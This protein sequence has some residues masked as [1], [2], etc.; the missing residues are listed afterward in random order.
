MI[1]GNAMPKLSDIACRP[2]ETSRGGINVGADHQCICGCEFCFVRANPNPPVHYPG[3]A[4]L[5]NIR[6]QI[7]EGQKYGITSFL[8]FSM[9][10]V[11]ICSHPQIRDILAMLG[12]EFPHVTFTIFTSG[13]VLPMDML[14]QLMYP[15]LELWI[16]VH[17][18]DPACRERLGLRGN[19]QAIRQL[20]PHARGG[21]ILEPFWDLDI[22]K[23]DIDEVR[24]TGFDGTFIVRRLE[25]TRYSTKIGTDASRASYRQYLPALEHARSVYPRVESVPVLPHVECKIPTSTHRAM[26]EAEAHSIRQQVKSLKGRVLFLTSVLAYWF[27]ADALDT[28]DHVTVGTMSAGYYG[29]SIE[30]AGLLTRDDI[31]RALAQYRDHRYQ[32]LCLPSRMKSQIMPGAVEAAG[33]MHP[34]DT[35]DD[36]KE[37]SGMRVLFIGK[38]IRDPV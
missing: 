7:Q 19:V 3:F 13:I 36:L 37:L 38:P 1:T 35:Y 33:L 23:K 11:E 2:P 20:M 26:L 16:S 22:F 32:Y 5:E 24:E 8:L 30:C 4:S 18:L 6:T 34:M 31:H 12:E 10:E 15:N 29:G 25:H 28:L 27:W 21:I 14:P 17:T 9:P